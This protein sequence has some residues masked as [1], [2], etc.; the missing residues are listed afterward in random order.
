M[1]HVYLE[2]ETKIFKLSIEEFFMTEA[3]TSWGSTSSRGRQDRGP[4]GLL[5][6]DDPYSPVEIMNSPYLVSRIVEGCTVDRLIY[7]ADP[8]IEAQMVSGARA[9]VAQGARAITG[10]CGF[11]MR[12]QAA[13][14]DAVDV[15]VFLSS[16]LLAPMLLASLNENSKLGLVTASSP[17]LSDGLLQE[18][19]VRDPSRIILADLGDKPNFKSG[20]LECTEEADVRMIQNE[21]LDVSRELVTAHPDVAMVLLECT[22]LPE[23]THAIQKAIHMPVFDIVSLI[24][25]FVQGF[26]TGSSRS[27]M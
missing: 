13:V 3:A 5:M 15:P 22:A 14:R 7:E 25:M 1:H 17:S 2:F 10:N 16:L 27:L 18:A 23:F 9:L 26:D 12:H 20:Y 8:T 24:D 4:I 6:L 21:T 11:M 19:G